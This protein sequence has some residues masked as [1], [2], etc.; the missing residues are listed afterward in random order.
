MTHDYVGNNNFWVAETHKALSPILGKGN[1]QNYENLTS[2]NIQSCACW[3]A[4]IAPMVDFNAR[5]LEKVYDIY[6]Y[7][8]PLFLSD[9]SWHIRY[10]VMVMLNYG[11]FCFFNQ[12]QKG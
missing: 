2:T 10:K 4:G 11:C 9:K 3:V 5:S 12:M 8:Y 6:I 7:Y 1:F